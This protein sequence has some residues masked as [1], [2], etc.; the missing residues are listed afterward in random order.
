MLLVWTRTA[1]RHADTGIWI[2]KVMY[3]DDAILRTA[4]G[5]TVQRVAKNGRK[6]MSEEAITES[7]T[8]AMQEKTQIEVTE[9]YCN[10]WEVEDG[11]S[12]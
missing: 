2:R 11:D 9:Q 8:E 7:L 6:R 10:F 5:C 4:V 1:V 3:T 12:D